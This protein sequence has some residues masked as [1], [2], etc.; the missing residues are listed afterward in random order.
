M[1]ASTTRRPSKPRPAPKK[2]A[3]APAPRPF[4]RAEVP[5]RLAAIE[6]AWTRAA[7]KREASPER[8]LA[9]LSTGDT[10]SRED[11]ARALGSSGNTEAIP[12]LRARL[13]DEARAVRSAAAVSLAR[14]GDRA[15]IEEMVKGLTDPSPR[16]VVGCALALGLSRRPE[17]VDP[18][19]A[20][21]KT[22]DRAVG[23]AVAGAL[24]LIGDKRATSALL[25]ALK[26]DF[27]PGDACDALGRLG[28][29]LAAP[30]LS[31]A[32][33]HKDPKVRSRAAR[34]LGALK[35]SLSGEPR[36]KAM[37]A[38]K[39]LLTDEDRKLRLAAALSLHELGDREAGAH[40]VAALS[41]G[42]TGRAPRH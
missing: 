39:K 3:P 25:E 21:F 24:G 29:A 37:A 7:A 15:L 36:A 8:L 33:K 42:L 14:L 11:A 13:S 1:N 40:V 31:K 23:A 41:L 16:N 34:A 20:A 6:P 2:A 28:D 5:K 18:L 38:L 19:L 22:H 4:K 26:A 17:A 12:A 35:D 10:A 27:V 9:R 32:L 30:A